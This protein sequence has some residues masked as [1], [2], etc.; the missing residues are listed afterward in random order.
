[1]Q[2]SHSWEHKFAQLV[3]RVAA[4][5]ETGRL[6]I[7]FSGVRIFLHYEPDEPV[8]TFPAYLFKVHLNTHTLLIYWQLPAINPSLETND[9]PSSKSHAHCP[10]RRS[11]RKIRPTVSHFIIHWILWCRSLSPSPN[12]HVWG[13]FL[14]SC[15]R[16]L[17]EYDIG[18][19]P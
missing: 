2:Q 3:K 8:H 5:Y 4:V 15:Q 10:L 7:M 9:F 14:V 13:P 12:P 17:T 19:L 18:E 16:L 6:I 1:M 11:F